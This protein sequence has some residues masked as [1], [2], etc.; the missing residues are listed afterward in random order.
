MN[1]KEINDFGGPLK[2]SG[3]HLLTFAETGFAV[4]SVCA[5]EFGIESNLI[6]E[7]SKKVNQKNEI[8]SMHPKAPIS[9]IPRH[10]IRDD[11][12][13]VTL[14]EQ[15]R[16][17]LTVNKDQIKAKKLLIDFSAGVAPFTV[18]ACRVA[19]TNVDAEFLDEVIII[20]D[21]KLS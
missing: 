2:D 17:F 4:L 8:G 21:S 1:I 16:G 9:A 14:A 3:F 15:I 19:L 7:F 11:F 5:E 18:D 12:D 10:C 20:C 13:S 6:E